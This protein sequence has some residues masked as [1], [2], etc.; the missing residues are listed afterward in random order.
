M[1]CVSCRPHGGAIERGHQ[2]GE[3]DGRALNLEMRHIG[4]INKLGAHATR[5]I[6]CA[7]ASNIS[8]W[9]A[10]AREMCAAWHGEELCP[11]QPRSARILH[12]MI[13]IARAAK[14]AFAV[15]QPAHERLCVAGNRSER[16]EMKCSPKPKALRVKCIER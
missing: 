10:C 3:I 7:R 13:G 15:I 2:A 6:K 8:V 12:S 14:R 5:D 1:A 11:W 9:L 4:I 16:N